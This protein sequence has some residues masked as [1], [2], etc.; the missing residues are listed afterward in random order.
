MIFDLPFDIVF[1]PDYLSEVVLTGWEKGETK[2]GKYYA[3]V[4]GDVHVSVVASLQDGWYIRIHNAGKDAVTGFWGV[5]FPWRKAADCFTLVPGIYY[6]G[7]EQPLTHIIPM[8]RE[9]D[10]PRFEASLSAASYPAVLFKDGVQGYSYEISPQ[11]VAGWNGVTLDAQAGSMT[12][13]APAMEEHIY[14]HR[15]FDD[16]SRAPY[17]LEGRS[18]IALRIVRTMFACPQVTDVFAHLW[19]HTIRS[20]RYPAWNQPKITEE[21]GAA[22]VRDWIFEKHCVYSANG[23]PLL[24]NAFTDLE[25]S[26]PYRDYY[27][28]WKTMIGWCDG[29]MTALPLLK[30]GG[31]YRA[32]AVEFLDFLTSQGDSSSGVKYSIYDGE[33]W[34][35]PAH[36]QFDSRYHHVRFYGDYVYYLGRSIRYEKSRGYEHPGWEKDFAHCIEVLLEIWQREKDFGIH[37]RLEGSKAEVY[38]KGTGAGAFAL[39][40]L[41]EGVRH[42]PQH[43]A[44]QAAF[45]EACQ[46]YYDRCVKT[47]RCNGGPADILEADDSESIAALTDA[48]VQQHMLFGGQDTLD[49][50]LDAARMFASWVMNYRPVFPGGSMFEHLNVCGGVL[51]NVQNRHV[52][53]GI[54]TNSG[55]FL[56]DLGKIT[57]DPR[58]TALYDRVKAAAI[59]CITSYDGEFY[60]L[61]PDKPFYKGMLSEQIN[62]TDALGISGE[63][64]RVSACWP[65]TSVLLGWFDTPEKD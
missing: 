45:R 32:F 52:G 30:Y 43:A 6:D 35:T 19:D 1:R 20:P 2:G 23:A 4:L 8:I 41:A 7:N 18:V 15:Q 25:G 10:R 21:E 38:E 34:M 60:E 48:L 13:F 39:L 50:A 22:L 64:W 31:K 28:E 3:A 42:F 51:A 9:E 14:R 40:A 36:P 29:P 24:L 54:C 17:E 61:S 33:A 44:L 57:G 16:V 53:P 65:A 11:S 63:S 37:W 56:Y 49:M 26:W 27:A 59:N 62:V 58:W 12:F 46:V 55:R 5:R 47:G